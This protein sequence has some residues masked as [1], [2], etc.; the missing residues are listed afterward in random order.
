MVMTMIISSSVKALEGPWRSQMCA[1]R[2]RRLAKAAGRLPHPRPGVAV[3]GGTS[4]AE[5][6]WCRMPGRGAGSETRGVVPDAGK[7]RQPFA[8]TVP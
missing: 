5:A 2:I 4:R 6:A 1:D 3:A 7:G 8:R